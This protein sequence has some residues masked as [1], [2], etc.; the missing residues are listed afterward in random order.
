MTPLSYR[1]RFSPPVAR[2]VAIAALLGA[3]LVAGPL[4]ASAAAPGTTYQMQTGTT[5]NDSISFE[6]IGYDRPAVDREASNYCGTHGKAAVFTGQSD[7]R[8]NYDCVPA[9]GNAYAPAPAN[10]PA[11]AYAP[12]LAYPPASAYAPV[13]AYSSYGNG[14]NNP[15]VSYDTTRY[16]RQAIIVAA[17][18]YCATQNKS[19]AFSGR[20]GS[21]VNYDCVP[22]TDAAHA[23]VAA[24]VAAPVVAYAPQA[25]PVVSYDFTGGN[26]QSIEAAA[27]SYCEAE[28]RTAVYRGQDGNRVTYDCVIGASRPY[29]TAAYNDNSVVP[30]AVPTITYSMAGNSQQ[31]NDAPAI[32]YCA[33]LGR[34]PVLRGE[35][36]ANRTY[37]CR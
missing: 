34:S 15:S 24:P 25:G 12:A 2:S 27:A 26:Q 7:V 8:L 4:T 10:A 19:A 37:E 1:L 35:D 3:T 17:D 9:S 36:G 29:T 13:A 31:N 22:Y 30:N 32:R 18:S 33:M 14:H 23:P 21:L 20:N 6:A 16:D 28:G 11:P 5:G